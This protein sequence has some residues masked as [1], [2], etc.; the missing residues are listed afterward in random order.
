MI[1]EK[2]TIVQKTLERFERARKGRASA[3]RIATIRETLGAQLVDR[4]PGDGLVSRV[5]L[6]LLEPRVVLP[7]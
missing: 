5:P 4:V 6:R 7:L 3:H 2:L 1:D